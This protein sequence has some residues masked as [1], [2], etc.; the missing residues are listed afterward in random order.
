MQFIPSTWRSVAVDGNGD[1]LT[2]PN[3]TFDAALGAGVYLCAGDTDLRELDDRIRAVRRY[4][5]AD[6][7]VR[8]VLRLAEMYEEGGVE[9]VE[10]VPEPAG[11]PLT[12]DRPDGIASSPSLPDAPSASRSSAIPTTPQTGGMPSRNGGG[13][14]S[15]TPRQSSAPAS[16]NGAPDEPSSAPKTGEDETRQPSE[17]NT[18]DRTPEPSSAPSSEPSVPDSTP[19]PGPSIT[20]SGEP[21]DGL[22]TSPSSPPSVSE[23]DA[24][25]SAA[26]GWAPAMREVVLAILGES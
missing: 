6:E 21:G 13:T 3:N 20:D 5:N 7:Y 1:E 9:I 23:P 19:S 18:A 25:S 26:V 12:V 10:S 16:P 24:A 8:L 17:S 11:P 4:N 22:T 15:T 2:D 14:P